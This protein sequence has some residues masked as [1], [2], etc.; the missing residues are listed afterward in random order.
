MKLK[1][2]LLLIFLVTACKSKDNGLYH[3]D[4]RTVEEEEITLTEFADDIT[5]IP[6]DNSFPVSLIYNPRY[7]IKN[8]IYISALNSGVMVFDRNGKFIR[9]IGSIG[10]GPGEYVH[11]FNFTV[12]KN[13]G[14]VYVMSS[15]HGIIKGYSKSGTFL[16]DISLK[17]FG[18]GADII[19]S[20]NSYLFVSFHP[21]FENVKYNWIILD[22]I[23]NI[24]SI[25]NRATPMFTSNW[26]IGGGV[27]DY[28]NKIYNWNPF[29]DTVF[30]IQHDL[31]YEPSFL[32]NPGDYRL[33]KSQIDM[34]KMKTYFNLYRVLETNRFLV[35]F[36]L[37][38]SKL[39]I[40]FI[41]KISMD[42]YST[43]LVSGPATV[44]NNYIGGIFND[45]D[46]GVKF[47]PESYFV[48]DGREYLAGLINAFQLKALLTNKEFQN[49]I[50]AHAEKKE[51]LVKLANNITE[52]DNQI[53]MIVRLKK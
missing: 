22:T 7:F 40:T 47:Q 51:K 9:K 18:D 31:K 38:D 50:P 25:K 21:Q 5:Y 36:Y 33:P 32:F 35:F 15:S 42:S 23:G 3:F 34:G 37:F 43:N 41:D 13:S 53:F 8:S 30:S 11:Y 48:E 39:T 24:V 1:Y 14:S 4:P 26:L 12:D 45:L 6:L 19:K 44:G 10:R 17:E 28:N 52:T 29:V 27:Y 20:Y 16:R 49:Y 2:L 46:G